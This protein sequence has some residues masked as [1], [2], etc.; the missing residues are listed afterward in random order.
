MFSKYILILFSC[1]NTRNCKKLMRK[2]RVYF[3]KDNSIQHVMWP[4]LN[5]IFIFTT[6]ARHEIDQ[7]DDELKIIAASLTRAQANAVRR[8]IDSLNEAIRQRTKGGDGSSKISSNRVSSSKARR[9][10]KDIFKGNDE[11]TS[12]LK[13]KQ[14]GKKM[15]VCS[16][17]S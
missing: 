17:L 15:Y 6:L 12:A 9:H 4:L 5:N 3:N 11:T 2:F 13:R 8:R 10:V 7:N 16:C 14:S 1:K